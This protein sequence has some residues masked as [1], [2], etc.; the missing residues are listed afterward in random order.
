MT[1][2]S[3]PRASTP[4]ECSQDAS[5]QDAS[6]EQSS[7]D[8]DGDWTFNEGG[9]LVF[10]TRCNKC[11]DFCQHYAKTMFQR[12]ESFR[13]AVTARESAV[14]RSVLLERDFIQRMRDNVTQRIANLRKGLAEERRKLTEA[15]QDRESISK[16]YST[17][18]RMRDTQDLVR[19][20][21]PSLPRGANARH[22]RTPS[23]HRVTVSSSPSIVALSP[24]PFQ[25]RH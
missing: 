14:G 25:R 20:R 6:D 21:S 1:A 17:V 11:D 4:A 10:H 13:A 23:P 7:D 2:S 15:R 12:G 16:I 9:F 22:V 3:R 24:P 19:S 18:S 5:D 8:P